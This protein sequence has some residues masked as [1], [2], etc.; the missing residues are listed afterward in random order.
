MPVKLDVSGAVNATSFVG[1][2]TIPVGG[3][4]MWSGTVANIPTSWALCNGSNGTPDLRGRFVVG[5][6]AGAGTGGYAVAASG[7]SATASLVDHRHVYAMDDNTPGISAID[8]Y[9]GTNIGAGGAQG[10]DTL[11]RYNTSK[12]KKNTG[13]AF[14]EADVTVVPEINTANLPPYYALAFIMRTT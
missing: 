5:A 3:I 4:I 14:S 1:N 2:G 11:K 7:G 13:A 8:N 9:A 12:P 10:G 6:S